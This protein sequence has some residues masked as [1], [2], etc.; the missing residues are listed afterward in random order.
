MA[1][2][3]CVRGARPQQAMH[4]AA[5]ARAGGDGV[6]A[7]GAHATCGARAAARAGAGGLLADRRAGNC[8]QISSV[9]VSCD[10]IEANCKVMQDCSN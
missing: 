6:R 1:T 8:W 3:A 5:M 2:A 10:N 7:R 4:A 9:V